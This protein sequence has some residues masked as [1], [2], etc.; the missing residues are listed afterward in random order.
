MDALDFLTHQEMRY[1]TFL[2]RRLSMAN[3]VSF[4]RL[5]FLR[6]HYLPFMHHVC[7]Q[8]IISQC[9]RPLTWVPPSPG[10]LLYHKL[11]CGPSNGVWS[12]CECALVNDAAQSEM[13]ESDLNIFR[14]V[15]GNPAL[16][17]Q[18]WTSDGT[19]SARP[20]DLKGKFPYASESPFT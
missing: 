20:E 15:N 12:E 6:I 11:G 5:R 7:Q 1:R 18:Y 16:R 4:Q 17:W 14:M 3:M 19:G 9:Q 8:G 10:S 2:N 13:I